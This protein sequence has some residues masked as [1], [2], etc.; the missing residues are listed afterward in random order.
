MFWY[1]IITL[2]IL[3][4]DQVTKWAIVTY[5]ELYETRSV[6]GEFFYIASHRNRGAAF[7]ILQDQRWFFIVVTLIVVA[8]LIVYLYKMSKE[9][10]HLLCIALSFLLA[11]AL[12]NFI[13]RVRTGEVVDF[14][15]F[16]FQF[17]FFGKAIDYYFA[18]F[19]VAD[20]AITL[21]VIVVM[22]DLLLQWRKEKRKGVEH[23]ASS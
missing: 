10:Q 22:L 18:T 17:N 3:V 21:G 2:I 5:M 16:R 23:D 13:D 4:L 19:N 20:T 6:I 12:G 15:L 11:G 8:V 7:G 1:Y 9:K 14:L